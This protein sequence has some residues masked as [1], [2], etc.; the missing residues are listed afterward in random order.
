VWSGDRFTIGLFAALRLGTMPC[1]KDRSSCR[2]RACC[3]SCFT[4]DDSP[5]ALFLNVPC[6]DEELPANDDPMHG[7]Q[8]VPGEIVGEN[9]DAPLGELSPVSRARNFAAQLSL[10]DKAHVK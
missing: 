4:G 8:T 10:M 2:T 9:A 7:T 1:S 5:V 3:C 6:A